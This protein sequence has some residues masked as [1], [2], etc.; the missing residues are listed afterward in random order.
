MERKWKR[1]EKEK[2]RP[3][4]K[5]AKGTEERKRAWGRNLQGGLRE[6][7]HGTGKGT[8]KERRGKESEGTVCRW[9]SKAKTETDR[10][11]KPQLQKDSFKDKE[12]AMFSN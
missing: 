12:F 10:R 11:G 2:K 3:R 6:E 5:F 4:K 9:A 8:S 1:E 7:G